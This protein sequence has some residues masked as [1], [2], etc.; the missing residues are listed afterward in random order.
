VAGRPEEYFES[1]V[2]TGTDR[3]IQPYGSGGLLNCGTEGAGEAACARS[4]AGS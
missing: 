1:V 4:T 3:Y 2:A